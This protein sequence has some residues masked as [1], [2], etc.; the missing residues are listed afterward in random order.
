MAAQNPNT[1]GNTNGDGGVSGAGLGFGP[2][3]SPPSASAS[4][5]PTATTGSRRVKKD[6][7]ALRV[8]GVEVIH[9][10]SEEVP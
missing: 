6:A 10:V 3:A 2:G 4:V 9:D 1:G 5:D 8:L 7:S